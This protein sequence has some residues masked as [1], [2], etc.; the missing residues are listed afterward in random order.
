L[1]ERNE[2]KEVIKRRRYHAEGYVLWEYLTKVDKVLSR[3]YERGSGCPTKF[4]F[5]AG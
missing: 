2:G 1:E 5:P 4:G 3:V